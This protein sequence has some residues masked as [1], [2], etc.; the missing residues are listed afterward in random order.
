LLLPLLSGRQKA[1]SWCDDAWVNARDPTFRAVKYVPKSML[2]DVV[3]R[4]VVKLTELTEEAEINMFTG[5]CCIRPILREIDKRPASEIDKILETEVLNQEPISSSC[6]YESTLANVLHTQVPCCDASLCFLCLPL[7]MLCDLFGKAKLNTFD[8]VKI[9]YRTLLMLQR[10]IPKSSKCCMSKQVPDIIPIR[11]AQFTV[12]S[13]IERILLQAIEQEKIGPSESVNFEEFVRGK[14]LRMVDMENAELDELLTN[15]INSIARDIS[16]L[17]SQPGD[18]AIEQKNLYY[19]AA[20]MKTRYER[21][22]ITN[23]L[24]KVIT[25]FNEKK[26]LKGEPFE[27]KYLLRDHKQNLR[28]LLWDNFI[29]L[30]GG[31]NEF[32]PSVLRPIHDL[33]VKQM[34]VVDYIARIKTEFSAMNHLDDDNLTDIFGM[35]YVCSESSCFETIAKAYVLSTIVEERQEVLGMMISHKLKKSSY[36][37]FKM[38]LYFGD[39]V[40]EIQIMNIQNYLSD[41]FV[42]GHNQHKQGKTK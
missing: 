14:V 19:K 24:C 33:I 7:S 36:I 28:G 8:E 35:K 10:Q 20:T 15:Q 29:N 12:L 41:S 13:E 26:I 22:L 32:V 27:H 1:M 11:A 39:A 30:G 21:T 3:F 17:R 2:R 16:Q 37:D 23:R 9:R 31:N 40:V 25:G 5:A 4:D 42:D 6:C 34:R 38:I 18:Q